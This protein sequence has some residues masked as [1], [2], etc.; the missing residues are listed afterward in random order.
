MSKH[1]DKKMSAIQTIKY[2]Y[3]Q[4]G[5]KLFTRGLCM[6]I[7]H[8]SWHTAFIIGVGDSK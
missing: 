7:I 3:Q 8:V 2:N 1:T 4:T 5:Y 6:R